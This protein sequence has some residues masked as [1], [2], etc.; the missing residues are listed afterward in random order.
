MSAAFILGAS[1]LTFHDNPQRPQYQVDRWQAEGYTAGARRKVD[2]SL[3]QEYVLTLEWPRMH[4]DDKDALL[5][6]FAST[7]SGMANAF[8]YRDPWGVERSVRFADSALS[9]ITDITPDRFNVAVRLA[10]Q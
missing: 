2:D 8:I 10:V 3:L 5:S 9:G 4:V 6:W 7:A 1:V